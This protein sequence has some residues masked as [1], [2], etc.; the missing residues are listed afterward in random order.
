M[1]SGITGRMVSWVLGQVLIGGEGIMNTA[2][3]FR[4]THGSIGCGLVH[5]VDVKSMR[6]ADRVS[7]C[8]LPRPLD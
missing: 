7:A 6:K 1:M 2:L 3:S 5:Y 4:E 8:K